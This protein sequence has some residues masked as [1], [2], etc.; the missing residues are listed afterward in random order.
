MSMTY[1]Q[2]LE[3]AT[4]LR[5]QGLTYPAI[6]EHLRKAGYIS[7]HSKGPIGSLAI[8]AMISRADALTT[9][10]PA[11]KT[12]T[13]GPLTAPEADILEVIRAVAGSDELSV[14]IRLT[15]V[16]TLLKTFTGA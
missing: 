8:R 12:A 4:T 3:Q 6:E 11:V 9:R 14:D 5:K 1:E 15:T 2:A 10:K 7:P 13:V 16:K